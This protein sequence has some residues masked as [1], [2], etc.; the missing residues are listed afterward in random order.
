MP[1]TTP[2]QIIETTLD[3]LRPQIQLHGGNVE[4][5]KFQNNIVYVRLTGACIGCPASIYT[6]KLGIEQA[7]KQVM[8][9]V[10]EVIA[11]DD[12]E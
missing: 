2:T 7:I 11:V 4:L 8:P 6:L 9:E 12:D 10:T 5:L 3:Q 1:N